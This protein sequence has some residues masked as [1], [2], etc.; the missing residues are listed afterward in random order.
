MLPL[1]LG[2]SGFALRVELTIEHRIQLLFQALSYI[3][4]EIIFAVQV[5]KTRL[6]NSSYGICTVFTRF[7]PF[8]S[9][10]SQNGNYHFSHFVTVVTIV[11]VFLIPA[12]LS[13]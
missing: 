9:E 11:T 13:F 10:G 7:L 6:T 1:F 2:G 3:F 8:Q 5:V 12:L 4:V